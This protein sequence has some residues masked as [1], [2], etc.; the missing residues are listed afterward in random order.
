[1]SIAR[2]TNI[3]IAFM[4]SMENFISARVFSEHPG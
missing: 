4:Q 3:S 1:M 2:L